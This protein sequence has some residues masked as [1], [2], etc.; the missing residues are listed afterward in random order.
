MIMLAIIVALT[1]IVGAGNG[2]PAHI[3]LNDANEFPE[4]SGGYVATENQFSLYIKNDATQI[5]ANNIRLYVTLLPSGQKADTSS[6]KVF[7][8]N[9]EITNWK[10]GRP[11]ESRTND[12]KDCMEPTS[13]YDTLYGFYNLGPLSSK[14]TITADVKITGGP[15]VIFDA[16][17]LNAEGK[18]I[19]K[20]PLSHHLTYD[21]PEFPTVALP[22]AAV[23]GLIFF[24]Q[25][26]KRKEE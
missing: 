21:I 4:S 25:H 19:L 6:Q 2:V 18:L 23:I 7:I 17:G 11:C 1:E 10:Y 14:N 15:K 8:N 12:N 20:D 24:F 3:W 16:W 26:K 9:V 22:I 13:N 5:G